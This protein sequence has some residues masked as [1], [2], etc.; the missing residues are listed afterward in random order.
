MA[1][2]PYQN[3]MGAAGHDDYS[4]NEWIPIDACNIR[5]REVVFHFAALQDTVHLAVR[6]TPPINGIRYAGCSRYSEADSRRGDP[7][8]ALFRS[9]LLRDYVAMQSC[10]ESCEISGPDSEVGVDKETELVTK[11][12]NQRSKFQVAVDDKDERPLEGLH[13]VVDADN[14]AEGFFF[15]L[16][17]CLNLLGLLPLEVGS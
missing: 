12:Q 13:I 3:F 4:L 6:M 5:I 11:A 17:R 8:G 7:A 15:L 14:G 10:E 1:K 9:M 2:I 16:K